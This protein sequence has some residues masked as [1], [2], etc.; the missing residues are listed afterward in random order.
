MADDTLK[1]A[2]L[3]PKVIQKR[4][5][6]EA[7]LNDDADDGKKGRDAGNLPGGFQ[8]SQSQFS[9]YPDGKRKSGPPADMLKK[10]ARD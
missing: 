2:L 7:G 9:K 8:M 1:N 4:R 6:Q 10:Q 5:E 3:N